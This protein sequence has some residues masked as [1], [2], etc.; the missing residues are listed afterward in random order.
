MESSVLVIDDEQ[1]ACDLL[2]MTLET[3]GARV[4][5]CTSAQKA[6]DLVVAGD[7]DAVLTDLSMSEMGGL[8]V[9]QRIRGI[10]PQL[11]V[12]VVTGL[13][14]MDAAI[15]AMRAGA[16]DFLTK[17]IDPKL[18]AISVARAVQH[19]RVHTEVKRL[20]EVVQG[21]PPPDGII[22]SS[23]AMQRVHDIIGRVAGSDA[24]V[25]IQGETGVGKELIARRIHETRATKGG[26]FVAINCAAVPPTLLESELFGHARGA[27]TDARSERVGLFVQANHGTLFLDE[28][29]ELPLEIQPK[30]LRALQE[31]TVRPVGAN[32]EIP[33]DARIV[34]ASNRELED[35]VEEKRFRQDLYYR[36]NVVRIVVPA[37]RE[38]D[39][40]VLELAQHFLAQQ[41]ARNHKAAIRLS[42]DV[43]KKLMEYRWP[44]N[45]RELENCIARAV[46]FAQYDEL[47]VDDL[48]EKV[49]SYEADRFVVSANDEMEIVTLQE[50]E[51]RYVARVLTLL[52][53]NKSRAAQV[54]GIDRRTL[55]RKA[56][57]WSDGAPG[58]GT[59][60]P[61]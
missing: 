17:P 51:R 57:K 52:G 60:Q 8:E 25:L 23:R 32:T 18:L 16:Y 14:S 55:Y 2:S 30:L 19:K 56:E 26:P 41:G 43:A 54:L 4:V 53:G 48:P 47:A 31:R 28:I 22:G 37:L 12:I 45:V 36:I 46:A 49:R 38:R 1:D 59:C 50:V 10:N 35:E 39:G 44:G 33:F 29:G 3:E 34:A 6:F 11:P 9:C 20:R 13:G 24:P 40:D 58:R 27:F 15:A 42:P 5:G 21:L 7:F 61:S